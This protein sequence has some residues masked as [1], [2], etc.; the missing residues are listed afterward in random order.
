MLTNRHQHKPICTCAYIGVYVLGSPHGS[1]SKEPASNAGGPGSIPGSE[2]SPG[3]GHG[4]PLQ[5]SCLD[6]SMDREAWW[7]I[8]HGV[9]K[10]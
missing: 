2:R 7:A 4:N 6:N 9:A 8:V 10:S 3:E 1:D 5:D